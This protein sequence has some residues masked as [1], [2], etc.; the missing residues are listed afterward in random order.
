[1][2]SNQ[3]P[4]PTDLRVFLSVARKGSFAAAAEEMSQ[5]PAY[6][7]KRIRILEAS[8]NT[9]LFHR[10][11]RNVILTEDGET[12]ERW[13]R[14]ILGDIEELANELSQ[15]KKSPT[16]LLHICSTFGFGRVHVGPAVSRFTEQYPNLDVCLELFDRPVDIIREGFDLEI[17]VG[18]DLPEQYV[19][20]KLLKNWRVLCASPEYLKK[21]GTPK[22]LH[23]LEKHQCIV[24][25]ERAS[26]FSTWTLAHDGKDTETVKVDGALSANHGEIVVNWALEGRG[27]MLRSIWDVQ[28]KIASGQL[29]QVLPRF[30]QEANI[31]AI[32]PP[33][34]K[35]SAKIRVC[36][37]SFK[38]YFSK[39]ATSH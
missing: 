25:R 32:Y 36:I 29:V 22:N 2:K 24:I 7:S 14:Q 9:K 1:M 35:Q 13:A 39:L 5:S 26:H 31:W 30:T 10:T 3:L 15:A 11:T 38:D 17:R 27:I 16:G 23:D 4:L 21:N 19:C 33:R 8:L 34:P 28:M 18:D 6:I 20:R 37:E 12:A